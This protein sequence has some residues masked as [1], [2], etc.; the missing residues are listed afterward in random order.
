MRRF[1]A[2]ARTQVLFVLCAS[3]VLLLSCSSTTHLTDQEMA[4]IDPRVQRVLAGEQVPGLEEVS[5]LRP[6]GSRE[7][8]IVVRMTNPKELDALGITPQSRFGD[9]ITVRVTAEEIK[10]LAQLGSVT[11]IRAGAPNEPHPTID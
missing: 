1:P 8:P 6:D 5:S 11:A 4:K 7:Y 10:K 9:M 3:C 2:V